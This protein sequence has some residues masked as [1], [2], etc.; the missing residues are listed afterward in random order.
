MQNTR[1]INL[2]S[3]RHVETVVLFSV[4]WQTYF[5]KDNCSYCCVKLCQ[6]TGIGRTSWTCRFGIFFSVSEIILF[7]IYYTEKFTSFHCYFYKEKNNI[8]KFIF[9]I[10]KLSRCIFLEICQCIFHIYC[11]EWRRSNVNNSFSKSLEN[12]L[13][14]LVDIQTWTLFIG[15]TRGW[16]FSA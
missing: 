13:S 16:R 3:K 6:F 2:L 15:C 12:K 9:F 5:D 10:L 11:T 14:F 7:L 4:N 8:L 1:R